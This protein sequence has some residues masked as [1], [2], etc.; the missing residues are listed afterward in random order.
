MKQPGGEFRCGSGRSGSC[1]AGLCVGKAD[2]EHLPKQGSLHSSDEEAVREPGSCWFR[3]AK[4][5]GRGLAK[6]RGPSLL[7][8]ARCGPDR[9]QPQAAVSAFAGRDPHA[10]PPGTGHLHGWV[11]NSQADHVIWFMIRN[12]SQ[13]LVRSG[14]STINPYGVGYAKGM[15]PGGFGRAECAR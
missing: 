4:D 14:A 13:S 12:P 6:V 9:S 7:V 8:S 1:S 10:G 11:D 5:H 2:P 3:D 15:P